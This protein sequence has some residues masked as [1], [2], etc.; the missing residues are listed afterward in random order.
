MKHVKT[1]GEIQYY[2]YNGTNKEGKVSKEQFFNSSGVKVT[3]YEKKPERQ[4]TTSLTGKVIE[5]VDKFFENYERANDQST[6]NSDGPSSSPSPD[7]FKTNIKTVGK[8]MGNT[9]RKEQK[10]RKDKYKKNSKQHRIEKIADF[11]TN[12]D[13]SGTATT[14]HK[15]GVGG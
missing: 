13:I 3:H 1:Y 15:P 9:A 8:K 6:E 2:L 10:K 12:D 4:S 7:K 14:I 11:S 5:S